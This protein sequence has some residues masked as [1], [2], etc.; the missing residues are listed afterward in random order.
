MNAPQSRTD[1]GAPAAFTGQIRPY[2]PGDEDQLVSLFERCFGR[3]A[4]REHW[5]WKLKT[6]PSPVENVWV[7]EDAGRLVF[8]YAAI[9]TRF[10]LPG[11]PA[12]VMTGA[13]AMTA[14]EYRRRGL[15]S[16][17]LHTAHAAWRAAGIPFILGLP[18]DQ[19]GT[20]IN[21]LGWQ[22]L[23]RLQWYVCPIRP[24]A[25][26]T[27]GRPWLRLLTP[28]DPLWNRAAGLLR[29]PLP[30]ITV[31]PLSVAGA[32]IDTLWASARLGY[33]VAACRDSQ[34]V[35]WRYLQPPSLHYR[36]L[37]AERAG[38]PVGYAAY[39][40]ESAGQRRVALLADLF[41]ARHDS[42]S[43]RALLARVL[44][45]SWTS[46]ADTVATLALPDTPL[47]HSLRR[48]GFVVGRALFGVYLNPLAGS[49]SLDG[50]R[51]PQQWCLAGGDF[52]AL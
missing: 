34:W 26:L 11:G 2:A 13:D 36:L 16:Q 9:P 40:L 19:W 8:Q 14:P 31:R 15:L 22:P 42:D 41:A 46:G 3:A 24:V 4:S 44:R 52:D 49:V 7:A 25:R 18:N 37:L 12:T 33:A 50:L 47:A 27:A 30:G 17:G 21:S 10:Q 20:R 1:P 32:E 39:R 35:N 28:L 23:H 38:L 43:R 45:D 51:D 5:R 48:A 6:Q 29:R